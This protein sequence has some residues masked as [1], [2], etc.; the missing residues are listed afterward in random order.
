LE[1]LDQLFDLLLE[2]CNLLV[3]FVDAF[4]ESRS[5]IDGLAM[6]SALSWALGFYFGLLIVGEVFQFTVALG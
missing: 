5:L 3:L 4:P 6:T 2:N 1:A